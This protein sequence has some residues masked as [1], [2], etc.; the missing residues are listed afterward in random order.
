MFT[1]LLLQLNLKR[2]EGSNE[3]FRSLY[4]PLQEL[5]VDIIAGGSPLR[6]ITM[7]Q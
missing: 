1:D 2:G 6:D 4:N 3:P 7:S 5:H